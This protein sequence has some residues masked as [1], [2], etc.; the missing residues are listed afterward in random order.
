MYKIYVVVPAYNVEK[1]LERCLESILNQ[2]Y[3]NWELVLVDD[4]S[5][6][7]S[8]AICD[9][10]ATKYKNIT[11]IHQDNSGVSAARNAAVE[12]VLNHGNHETDWISF[13][14]SD[15][16][17]HPRYLEFL[18][19]AAREGNTDIS[20]CAYDRTESTEINDMHRK[21]V[22]FECLSPEEYFC[23][24]PPNANIGCAKLYRL[25]LLE[26]TRF[27]VGKIYED[28]FTTHRIL[29]QHPQITV[30]WTPLYY[31]YL[32]NQSISRSEWSPVRIDKLDALEAQLEFFLK[33]EYTQAYKTVVNMLFYHSVTQYRTVNSLS[34]RYDMLL[35]EMK[36]RQNRAIKLYTNT[37]GH[38][39]TMLAWI[40]LRIK[41]PIKHALRNKTLFLSIKR[42]LKRILQH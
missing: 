11:V 15:D 2:T 30:I 7:R 26:F 25:S 40:D 37:F 27:P 18:H 8:S 4:G 13:V 39:K 21:T 3:A 22:E 9:R 38:G 32:N 12:Y 36:N 23:R 41:R 33:N 14:D 19:L 1:Y 34:P 20:S 35:P 5:T 16:F 24:K 10:Y 17:V 29:F 6:D 31:W 42:K 28:D